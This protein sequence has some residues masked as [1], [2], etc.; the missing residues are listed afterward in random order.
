MPQDNEKRATVGSVRSKENVA[1]SSNEISLSAFADAMAMPAPGENEYFEARAYLGLGAGLNEA[2]D[3]VRFNGPIFIDFEASS[4]SY[5][6]WPIEVGLAWLED[7]RVV[8]E[9]KLIKPRAEWSIADWD[10]KSERVHGIS[11]N[12]L[13]HAESADDVADWLVET[14]AG[15]PLVSDAPEFDQRWLSRLLGGPGPDL[16]DFHKALWLAFSDEGVVSPGRLHRAYENRANRKTKHRAGSD[17]ADLCYAWR[18]GLK[19]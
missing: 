9:S 10:P 19:K 7:R 12:E 6:S 1:V 5:S 11:R 8:V 14:V 2:G 15:S 4:L 16:L 17:A 13:E 3:L 18:A